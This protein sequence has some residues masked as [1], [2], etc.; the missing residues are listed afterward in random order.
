M[1][2]LQQIYPPLK[3][4]VTGVSIKCQC[5]CGRV[6]RHIHHN[7]YR[8]KGGSNSPENLTYL[9]QRC[10][11]AHHSKQG[12]FKKWGAM[13]GQ[14]TAEKLVSIPNLV[15]FRGE[16]GAKRFAA[17]VNKRANAQMGIYVS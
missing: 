5:G 7:E 3:D 14:I 9:C 17:W 10:H 12:D 2:T 4:T 11:V 8:C 16:E 1:K 6:A 15:Q 13:G